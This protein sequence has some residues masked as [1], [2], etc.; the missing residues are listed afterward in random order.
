M[1]PFNEKLRRVP[2]HLQKDND[3][4]IEYMLAKNVIESSS[5]PWGAGVVLVKKKD[6]YTRFCVDCRKLNRVTVKDAYPLPRINDYLNQMSGA[7]WFSNIELCSGY[8]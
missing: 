6:G 4:A 2:Y 8:W 1:K 7:K 5:R 3:K